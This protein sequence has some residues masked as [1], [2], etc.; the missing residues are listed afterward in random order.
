MCAPFK[1]W[2][3]LFTGILFFLTCQNIV[4]AQPADLQPTFT[5]KNGLPSSSI[6]QILQDTEG[7]IWIATENGLSIKNANSTKLEQFQ[8]NYTGA[9]KQIAFARGLIYIALND[10][11]KIV[12]SKSLQLIKSIPLGPG[13]EVRRLRVIK[14]DIWV[15]ASSAVFRIHWMTPTK[16]P[17]AYADKKPMDIAYFKNRIYLITYPHSA[18]LVFDGK[19]FTESGLTAKLN[20]IFSYNY[21]SLLA[22][23]DTLIVG[24]DH[25]CHYI[26]EKKLT[27]IKKI[28]LGYT[29]FSNPAIWDMLAIGERIFYAVGNTHQEDQGTVIATAIENV[30]EFNNQ[31]YAQ[32]LYYDRLN[33]CLYI[34]TKHQGVFALKD[35]SKAYEIGP[36]KVADGISANQYY[37]Y[38]D[39]TSQEKNNLYHSKS[40]RTNYPLAS[41][42]KIKTIG[43]TTYI[44]STYKV[45]YVTPHKTGIIWDFKNGTYPYSIM[46]TDC[47]RVGDSMYFFNLYNLAGISDLNNTTYRP[48]GTSNYMPQVEK[49]GSK[50]LCYNEG[51]GF[52]I[53]DAAGEHLVKN[54]GVTLNNIDDFTYVNDTL[55]TLSTNVIRCYVIKGYEF[56]LIHTYTIDDLIEDFKADWIV[57]SQTGKLYL[58]SNDA[59]IKWQNGQLVRYHYF[60]RRAINKKPTFDSF[61][62]LLVNAGGFVTILEENA[63]ATYA[64]STNYAID[65]PTQLT[66]KT[67]D[68]LQVFHPDYFAQ[69]FSLKKIIIKKYNSVVFQKWFT[70]NITEIPPILVAGSYQIEVWADSILIAKQPFKIT[71]PLNR[72]PL[73]YLGIGLL[74]LSI[75]FLIFRL[76]YNQKIYAK[77][78]VDNK[79]DMLNKNLNPHFIFNSLNL[80]Y[81][82]ILDENKEAALSVLM[83]FSKLQRNFLERSKEKRVTL[84]TELTFI[85]S[86][87]DIE[88]LRYSK[89]IQVKYKEDIAPTIDPKNIYIPPN[90]LQPLVENSLKYGGI[91]YEGFEE[92]IIILEVAQK[93]EAVLLSIENPSNESDP[94]QLE[95]RGF[96]MGIEIVTE[97][98]KLYNQEMK[99]A[100]QLAYGLPALHFKKGYRVELYV[101]ENSTTLH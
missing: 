24:G 43:D 53:Y 71:V 16:V 67:K 13:N 7:R 52:K 4:Q 80:I 101:V 38:D 92:K 45:K 74:L 1:T 60:G 30:N 2:P 21:L 6:N 69:N 77:R 62:R 15:T 33:D 49:A 54:V 32:S 35:I 40:F 90:I 27:T 12:E 86:Y 59:L 58:I 29:S 73:F 17:Y 46:F 98:I 79:I 57:H 10:T 64:V 36:F 76:K 72:N 8:K 28:D 25:V 75:L 37:L 47:F 93:G 34:G 26:I 44:L 78:I 70:S 63:L 39:S 66:E 48:I 83:K 42:K 19:S 100:Y 81:S 94:S 14:Q 22:S 85:R 56:N 82:N 96:G 68:V 23:G 95:M 65:I 18:L 11:I 61:N 51:K 97:R 87:L 5:G 99:T 41:L 55:Y 84:A 3:S 89:D 9:I 31:F 91:G 88:F 20:P 50:L